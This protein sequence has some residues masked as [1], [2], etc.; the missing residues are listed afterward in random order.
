MNEIIVDTK[1]DHLK[2][3]MKVLSSIEDVPVPS[4]IQVKA[5][6]ELEYLNY[7]RLGFSFTTAQAYTLNKW[8]KLRT[9]FPALTQLA[10]ALSQTHFNQAEIMCELYAK[11]NG[12]PL[13]LPQFIHAI[14]GTPP[15]LDLINIGIFDILTLNG[16]PLNGEPVQKWQTIESYLKNCTNVHILPY[17]MAT[18]KNDVYNFWKT[19]VHDG[20]YEGLVVRTTLDTF[21]V[22]PCKDLDCVIIALKKTQSYYADQI[23]TIRVALMD[24]D[25]NLVEIG[26]VASGI[27]ISLRKS[28]WKLNKFVVGEDKNY[29]YIQPFIICTIEYTDLFPARKRILRFD[30]RYQQVGLKRLYSCRHPRLI[31]FRSDKSLNS[32]D[33]SLNQLPINHV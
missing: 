8:G 12:K 24:Y 28:L 1:I 14:K 27:D 11:Q 26:D 9:D 5:D 15:Q 2:P 10:E 30:G 7:N 13:I 3:S 18:T 4:T 21:K 20:K 17:T 23:A 29:I 31:R 16:E 25:N 32:K 6:G 22:K 33:L 19:H